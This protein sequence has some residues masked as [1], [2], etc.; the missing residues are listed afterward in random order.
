[1]DWSFRLLAPDERA[2]LRALTVFPADFDL[3]AAAAVIGVEGD[4]LVF[5][6]VDKS[7]VT[8]RTGTGEMRYSLLESVRAFAAELRA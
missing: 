2:A 4:D 1:M 6:L 8:A 5:R 7:L 3:A